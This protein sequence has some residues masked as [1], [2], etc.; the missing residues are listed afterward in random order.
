MIRQKY[1]IEEH[2]IEF[3]EGPSSIDPWSIEYCKEIGLSLM[4]TCDFTSYARID[5]EK[6]YHLRSFNKRRELLCALNDGSLTTWEEL[7][8]FFGDIFSDSPRNFSEIKK[9]LDDSKRSSDEFNKLSPEEKKE[10]L[11]KWR[12]ERK[13]ELERMKQEKKQ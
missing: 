10:Y 2:T 1:K 7:M 6:I 3:G 13:A 12:A 5:G 9:G 4:S 11:A 8:Y